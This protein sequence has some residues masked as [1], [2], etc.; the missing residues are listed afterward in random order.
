MRSHHFMRA[1]CA[2][3]LAA[4]LSLAASAI[5]QGET[6]SDADGMPKQ[7]GVIDDTGGLPHV[8]QENGISYISGGAGSDEA[9]A[10]NRLSG[11]FNLKLTMTIP[12]GQYTTP[13]KLR[14]E[15]SRGTSL[16]EVEP[17]GPIFLAKMPGGEY[18]IQAT[19]EGQTLTRKV[20]VPP[21]G[22]EAVAMTWPAKDEPIRA[23]DAPRAPIRAGDAPDAPVRPIQ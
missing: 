21:N 22:L 9:D 3:I 2:S 16:L 18:V 19:A 20:T 11:Q 6:I 8:K 13:R 7:V 5:A 15:D 1:A 12:S 4:G 23:G 17:S 10:L 14:I